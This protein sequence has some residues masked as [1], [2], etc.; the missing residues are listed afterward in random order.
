MKEIVFA[1]NNHHK[2]FEIRS[3]LRNDFNVLSLTDIGYF[4]EIPETGDTLAMNASQKSHTIY[5]QYNVDC[6]SD[7]TGLDIDALNGEPG[8]YSA[9]YAGE[10]ASYDDNVNLVL[11]KLEGIENREASFRTVISLILDGKEFQ[12]EGRVSGYIT[13]DKRGSEGFGYD[14]IFQPDGFE[15]TFAELPSEI[16]NKIS[17]RAKAMEKLVIFLKKQLEK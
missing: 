6:F 4:K 15:T 1:T 10:N 7:D 11:S 2:L 13:K 3:I 8:V 9:R 14:P 5:D 17:H 12:F 16:K